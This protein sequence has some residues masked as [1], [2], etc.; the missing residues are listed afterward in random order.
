MQLGH[1]LAIRSERESLFKSGIFS[2]KYLAGAVLLTF[3]LQIAAVYIPDL[4]PFFKTTPLKLDE[5]GIILGTASLVFFAVELE[6]LIKRRAS[7]ANWY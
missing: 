1:V 4:N 7:Q 5:L 3:L 6:K 2:N